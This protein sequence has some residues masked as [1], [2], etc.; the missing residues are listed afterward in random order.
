[1]AEE[2]LRI[3]FVALGFPP[4]VGGTERYNVE[5]ARRLHARGHAL[6]VFAFGADGAG[7]SVERAADAALP[8]P[9]QR[10][11]GR[12]RR[13]QLEPGALPA[14]LADARPDVVLVSR[15]SRRLAAVASVAAR[16]APLVVSVHELAGRHTRRGVI[17]RWRVRHRYGLGRARHIVVNSRDTG[18]RV[19]SLRPRAPI[20]VVYPGVD[21]DAFAVDAELRRAARERLG[22]TG[23]RVL[24][25]VSRLASN[26]GHA[27]VIEALPALRAR[28]PDLVYAVVGEGAERQALEKFAAECG[29]AGAVRFEGR[30]ADARDHY[31]AADVFVMASGRTGAQKAG[32][33]FGIVYAEAGACG[34]PVVASASGGGSDVV[35]DGE[36]GRL[37]DP[38]AVGALEEALAGLLADP[39]AARRLGEAARRHCAGFDWE[40]GVEVLEGVLARAA[41]RAA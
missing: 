19:A 21:T 9:V 25:T 5:Y 32:E 35:I 30:V 6:R 37:V 8:F 15:A 1:V 2:P 34:L 4:A 27:R 11:P 33:G 7:A 16:A 13:G 31:A 3:A 20:E 18:R 40:R 26:K 36:T 10:E 23:R 41:G 14:W 24:L 39:D 38:C 17:G 12:E 22:L 28:F 29:V